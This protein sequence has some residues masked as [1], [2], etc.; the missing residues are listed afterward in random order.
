MCQKYMFYNETWNYSSYNIVQESDFK[1]GGG[2]LCKDLEEKSEKMFK[3]HNS[4]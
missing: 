4:C 3:G 2:V 1:G